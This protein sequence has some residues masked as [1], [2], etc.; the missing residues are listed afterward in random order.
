M[1]KRARL[2][3]VS[4]KRNVYLRLA[5]DMK[6]VL[7]IRQG[8]PG[9]RR[10]EQAML[11]RIF[12]NS[13]KNRDEKLSF[14]EYFALSEGQDAETRA[15]WKNAFERG[16]RNNDGGWSLEEYVASKRRRVERSEGGNQEGRADREGD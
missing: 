16:D 2:P 3:A 15:R 9:R 7:S 11:L 12:R 10:R 6:T 14:E 5:A 8:D 13:D 4:S 1:K